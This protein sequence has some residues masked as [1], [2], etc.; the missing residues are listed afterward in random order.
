[1]KNIAFM[2]LFFLCMFCSMLF[3]Q[4][5][6]EYDIP[7]EL[8]GESKI[9]VTPEN[10]IRPANYTDLDLSVPFF[11]LEPIE[12]PPYGSLK[13][14]PDDGF[15]EGYMNLKSILS[16]AY[17]LPGHRVFGD[18]EILSQMYD[19]AFVHTNR[20]DF[21][22]QC[23]VKIVQNLPFTLT[24][25]KQTVVKYELV[26]VSEK[27]RMPSSFEKVGIKSNKTGME[28]TSITPQHLSNWIEFVHGV[29]VFTAIEDETAF[30]LKLRSEAT[31]DLGVLNEELEK[32]LGLLLVPFEEEAWVLFVE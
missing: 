1:M 16:G 21:Y 7:P 15:A 25:K 3:G 32:K 17:E 14:R 23:R 5:T 28:G 2:L 29:E 9:V 26:Q 6:E 18:K 27:L 31:K 24:H 20:A 12:N 13:F 30:D 11:R 4:Q 22:E 8:I 19:F 10:G